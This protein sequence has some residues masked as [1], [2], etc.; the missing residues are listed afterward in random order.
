MSLA[1]R[2]PA[3]EPSVGVVTTVRRLIL[4]RSSRSPCSCPSFARGDHGQGSAPARQVTQPEGAPLTVIFRGDRMPGARRTMRPLLQARSPGC[5]T[6]R[7]GLP[8]CRPLS[9]PN[10][11]PKSDTWERVM[12]RAGHNMARD[13]PFSCR[14]GRI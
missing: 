9:A 6:D 2:F 4:Y 3:D 13:L 14:G 7:R 11:L 1:V 5:I 10:G 12:Q 8:G